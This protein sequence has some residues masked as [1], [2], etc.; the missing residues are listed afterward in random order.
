MSNNF[1][2][3]LLSGSATLDQFPDYV[4]KWHDDDSYDGEVYDYL[5]L[6]WPEYKL[7]VLDESRLRYVA[8]ARRHGMTLDDILPKQSNFALAARAGDSSELSALVDYLKKRGI[9]GG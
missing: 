2:N 8:A 7:V 9:V 5:G 4:A 6:T 3:Q 1:M